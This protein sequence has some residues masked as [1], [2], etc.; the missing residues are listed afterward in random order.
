MVAVCDQAAT[1]IVPIW[2]CWPLHVLKQHTRVADEL[3]MKRDAWLWYL[4]IVVAA[5][6]YY[7]VSSVS[8]EPNASLYT[9]IGVSGLVAVVAGMAVNRRSSRVGWSLAVVSIALYLAGDAVL[10]GLQEESILVPFPST[11]DWLYL[12]MYPVVIV[13]VVMIR[14][15]VVPRRPAAD[16]VDGAIIGVASFSVIG[17]IYM[18]D[19]FTNDLFGRQAQIVGSAYPVFDVMLIAVAAWF[20]LGV[21]RVAPGLTMI[22]SGLVLVAVGNAVFNVQ[23]TSFAFESG[24]VADLCWLGFTSLLGAAALHPAT[25]VCDDSQVVATAVVPGRHWLQASALVAIPIGY[26]GW[27]SSDDLTFTIASAVVAIGLV[28]WTLASSRS[29]ARATVPSAAAIASA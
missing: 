22:A 28:G 26:V 18:N 24:G 16:M 29:T 10:A 6:Q 8:S 27:G 7:F 9:I 3:G 17:A 2:R 23:N 11:A 13:A 25:G 4:A 21:G 5:G 20:A 19:L 1:P 15:S 14:R 12:A